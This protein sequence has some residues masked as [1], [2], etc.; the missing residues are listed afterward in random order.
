MLAMLI[1]GFLLSQCRCDA[2]IFSPFILFY[3]VSYR[4]ESIQIQATFKPSF[5]Y[6]FVPVPDFEQVFVWK[7]ELSSSQWESDSH[8]FLK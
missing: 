3:K 6:I 2:I 4:N 7:E 5:F 1:L 8:L